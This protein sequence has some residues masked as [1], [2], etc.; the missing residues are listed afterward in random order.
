MVG[1]FFQVVPV[2]MQA[3][4]QFDFVIIGGGIAG[5]SAAYELSRLG[6]VCLVEREKVVA[7]KASNKGAGQFTV[8]II[9][10][11]M[12]AMAMASRPFFETPPA[13]DYQTPVFRQ[14]G[15]LTVSDAFDDPACDALFRRLMDSGAM[16]RRIDTAEAISLFSALRPEV[17]S[18]GVYEV[19]AGDI[20]VHALLNGYLSGAT[21]RGLVLETDQAVHRI[22]KSG[23]GW[24]LITNKTDLTG[25]VVINAAGAWA[26]QIAASSGLPQIGLHA[27]RRTGFELSLPSELSAQW[28]HVTT[29]RFDWYIHPQAARLFGSPAEADL[30]PPGTAT[31]SFDRVN[32]AI[33]AI[34]RDTVLGATPP[35]KTWAGLRTFAPD[36]DPVCGSFA[37]YPG[38][39]VLAGQG[40]C[41]FLTAP[42]MAQSA[43]SLIDLG[44]LPDALSETGLK[45]DDLSPERLL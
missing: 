7:Q 36:R 37:Q 15:V 40:G 29:T 12:R 33:A 35:S 1:L 24:R 27:F 14:R 19:D 3:D 18:Q 26:D 25:T 20:D 6:R 10:D 5:L 34:N 4:M 9:A 30:V 22:E 23:K 28:P 13:E 21:T 17:V 16:A 2:R 45:P 44:T 43:A 41:G 38:Y 32:A 39:F 11:I 8:G 31:A 42:A